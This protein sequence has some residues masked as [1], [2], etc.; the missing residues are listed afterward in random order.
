MKVEGNE[1]N[2]R[3]ALARISD[4]IDNT[5]FTSQFIKSKFLSHEVNF[6]A[7]EIKSLQ[8][9]HSLYFTDETFES[10]LLHTLLMIRR[11]KMKQPISI[12]PRELAAVK[13]RKNIN[14]LLLVYN[15]LSRFLQSVFLKKKPCI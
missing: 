1:K 13:R 9:K 7:K 3:K 6:V 2:K 5:E 15:G 8:K 12:S 10:L 14:G 4:L 11:I